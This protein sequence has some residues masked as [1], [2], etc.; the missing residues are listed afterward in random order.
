MSSSIND[1]IQAISAK[2]KELRTTDSPLVKRMAIDELR[3]TA[4]QA[5]AAMQLNECAENSRRRRQ[6]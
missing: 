4:A 1:N 3:K 2:Y 5:E 6:I